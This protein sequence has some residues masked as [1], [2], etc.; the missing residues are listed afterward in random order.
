MCN[1]KRK[2]T[3]AVCFSFLLA[4]RV[5][6]FHDLRRREW[7]SEGKKLSV[8]FTEAMSRVASR[9]SRVSQATGDDTKADGV[10]KSHLR[11]QKTKIVRWI[12]F[13][14]RYLSLW[15]SDV[16][17]VTDVMPDGVVG[18]HHIALC[19]WRITSLWASRII[20]IWVV[21]FFFWLL[22]IMRLF[23]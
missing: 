8:V 11:N 20:P 21:E 5:C 4:K 9:Q 13:L 22:G 10:N 15:T 14:K 6:P 1:Q 18:K 19:H 23:C 16:Y 7:E 2:H 3:L 12:A 17:C